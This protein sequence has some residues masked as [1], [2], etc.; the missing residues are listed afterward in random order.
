MS[1][2]SAAKE[3]EDGRSKRS[4]YSVPTTDDRGEFGIFAT[5]DGKQQAKTAPVV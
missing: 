1:T 3:R 4:G 2:V 5:E